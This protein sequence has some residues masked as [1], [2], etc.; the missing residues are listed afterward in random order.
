MGHTTAVIGS[1][2]ARPEI[3]DR[4]RAKDMVQGPGLAI[5]N[6]KVKMETQG[7]DF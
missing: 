7:L 2:G 1:F 3:G 6:S 5:K 4:G